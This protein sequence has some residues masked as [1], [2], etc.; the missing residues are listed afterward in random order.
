MRLYLRVFQSL[1]TLHFR[2]G[3]A[4]ELRFVIR[5]TLQLPRIF[6]GVQCHKRRLYS[7]TLGDTGRYRRGCCQKLSILQGGQPTASCQMKTQLVT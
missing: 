3:N 1:P 2:N 7:C 6:A 5:R 4:L